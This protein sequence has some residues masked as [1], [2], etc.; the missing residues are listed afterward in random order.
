MAD[1]SQFDRP[2]YVISVAAEL[3]AMH[4]QTLRMYE[5]RG[6]LTPRRLPN[7]R[8]MYSVH[9]LERLRRIQEL[10]EL[11]LNLAGIEHVLQLEQ[12][13]AEMQREM[14]LLERRLLEASQ[15]LRDEVERVERAH[16]HELVPVRRAA[17]LA[18]RP[19]RRRR[20]E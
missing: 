16:R 20:E 7:N 14:G 1:D 13:M 3:V 15:R 8:R 6:L 19:E 5:R 9:D 11:G 18:L 12:R 2:V 4:P 10:S 17:L